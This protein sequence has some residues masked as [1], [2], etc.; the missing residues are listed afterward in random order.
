MNA[1]SKKLKQ[2]VERLR[3]VVDGMDKFHPSSPVIKNLLASLKQSLEVTFNKKVAP[4]N[5]K[6][7]SAVLNFKK[8]VSRGTTSVTFKK[9][10]LDVLFKKRPAAVA[11][12]KAK[13]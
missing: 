3:K 12:N 10:P 7:R 1:K 9:R 11:F 8:R 5:F 2:A 13:I 4:L 6:K